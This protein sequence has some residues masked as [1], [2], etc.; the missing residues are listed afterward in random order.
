MKTPF[1]I[2]IC[3]GT[4]FL[5]SCSNKDIECLDNKQVVIKSITPSARI[6]QTSEMNFRVEHKWDTSEF[7]IMSECQAEIQIEE[8]EASWMLILDKHESNSGISLQDSLYFDFLS[9]NP[10]IFKISDNGN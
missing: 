10:P 1:A 8:L 6:C 3:I 7:L 2:L 4:L 9:N 5:F